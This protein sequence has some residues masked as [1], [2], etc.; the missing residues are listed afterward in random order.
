M[1]AKTIDVTIKVK[2]SDIKDLVKYAGMEI[3]D[4]AA[5][6]E[7][8]ASA[9]F[10][11]ELATDIYTVWNLTNEEANGDLDSQV[12]FLLKDTVDYAD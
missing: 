6:K 1:A 5:F 3:V 9:E 8:I 4:K 7:R 12:Q 10:A 11:R 2:V